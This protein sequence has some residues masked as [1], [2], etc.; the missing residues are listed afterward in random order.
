MGA[1]GRV[2]TP[3]TVPPGPSAGQRVAIRVQMEA[4]A[5]CL[6]S[7]CVPGPSSVF[8]PR[9]P[10]LQSPP[11]LLDCRKGGSGAPAPPLWGLIA[12]SS[13]LLKSKTPAW[14][15][16]PPSLARPLCQPG[17]HVPLR[18]QVPYLPKHRE[19]PFRSHPTSASFAV[20]PH[21]RVFHICSLKCVSCSIPKPLL[22]RLESLTPSDGSYQGRC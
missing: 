8:P 21:R 14:A 7:G 20:Q 13:E 9:M 17:P 5:L 16:C 15:S 22:I 19:N 3:S 6:G 4:G 18:T 10:P 12:S 2:V 1:L 11:P